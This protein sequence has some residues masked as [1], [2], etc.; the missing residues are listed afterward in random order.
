MELINIYHEVHVGPLLW[1]PELIGLL[2]FYREENTDAPT[3]LIIDQEFL[4][5]C[6]VDEPL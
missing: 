3:I 2:D 6:V 1:V 4:P 5:I